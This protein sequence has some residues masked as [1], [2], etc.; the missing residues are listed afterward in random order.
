M[1]N[2]T[3]IKM[4][5][6]IKLKSI[7]AVIFGILT[8]NLYSQEEQHNHDHYK[9][10]LG[11]ANS[12]VYFAKEKEFAYGLHLHIVRNI[13]H[14][15]FGF[16]VGYERI[17]DEHKHNTIGLVV[18]YSLLDDLLISLSPGIAFEGNEFSN[19]KFACS[20]ETSYSFNV[21]ILHLGP[22]LEFAYDQED[23]HISLGLHIGY[24]F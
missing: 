21:G 11:I 13:H 24:G 18:N 7:L 5:Y 9:N 19:S 2:K 4:N 3:I 12:I 10:E 8:V 22:L 1:R 14:S 15:K 6:R 23:Y 17:F 16:G 20:I